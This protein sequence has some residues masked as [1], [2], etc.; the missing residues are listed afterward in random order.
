MSSPG[1]G[2][3]PACRFSFRLRRDGTVQRHHLY[4]G[5]DRQLEACGGSGR[6][7]WTP[8]PAGCGACE[9]Y[10]AAQPHLIGA[11]ASVGITH[12]KSTAQMIREHL[13]SYHERGHPE[14]A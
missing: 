7:P 11:L 9:A 8:G 12:G 4:C 1:R 14:A 10:V 3:C 5:S 13:G 2:Q 6:H